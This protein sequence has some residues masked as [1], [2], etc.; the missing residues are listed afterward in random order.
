MTGIA[1]RWDTRVRAWMRRGGAILAS[2][3]LVLL[4][5]AARSGA[6]G[7]PG[8]CDGD[9]SVAIDELVRLV[10]IAL[11]SAAISTCS[12][13]DS[14][15]NGQVSI[16]EI[17]TAVFHGLNGCAAQAPCT[18]AS[19]RACGAADTRCQPGAGGLY[20]CTLSGS[21]FAQLDGENGCESSGVYPS[22]CWTAPRGPC[23]ADAICLVANSPT[24]TASLT[25]TAS[26]TPTTAIP[27][28]ITVTPSA[29]GTAVA[30]ATA[31]ATPTVQPCDSSQTTAC[32]SVCGTAQLGC[33]FNPTP[34]ATGSPTPVVSCFDPAITCAGMGCADGW[35]GF[36]VCGGQGFYTDA[37]QIVVGTPTATPTGIPTG[38]VSAT[39]TAPPTATETPS[40]PAATATASATATQAAPTGT[41]SASPASPTATPTPTATGPAATCP[42]GNREL[43]LTNS[44]G[45]TIWIGATGGAV[46]PVCDCPGCA[47]TV[48]LLAPSL[49]QADQ[50]K[51]AASDAA[52]SGTILC[53]GTSTPNGTYE[54]CGCSSSETCGGSAACN[55]SD[56]T[57]YWTVPTPTSAGGSG[58]VWEL[59]D[60][61]SALFCLPAPAAVG[62]VASPVWWSGN[63]FART[64]CDANGAYCAAGNCTDSSDAPCPPGTGG[65]QGHSLFEVTLQTNANDFYDVS[66]INGAN[67]AIAAAPVGVPTSRPGSVD[68]AYWCG[69]PGAS[70]P[71]T[72]VTPCDWAID[73]GAIP[74]PTPASP[75]P[76]AATPTPPDYRTTLLLTSCPAGRNSTGNLCYQACTNDTD[77]PANS[78]G[79]TH[80]DDGACQCR[81]DSDCAGAYLC[82]TQRAEFVIPGLQRLCGDFAGWWTADDICST[83][84]GLSVTT[85]GP[86]DCS[87]AMQDLLGCTGT[88][89]AS[90]YNLAGQ[91]DPNCCGCATEASNPL[92]ADWPSPAAGAQCYDNNT[93]WA[94]RAQPLLAYLKVACPTAYTYPFDDPTS[95]F[96]C[97]TGGAT[98][99]MGYQVTFSPLPTPGPAMP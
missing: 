39:S 43:N 38:T 14:D 33:C 83:A 36:T 90:C 93:T 55:G 58:S 77:C 53:P 63:I 42:A 35:Y 49:V 75:T 89:A 80:C 98:N 50:C 59:S 60:G 68:P 20:C 66:I 44:S 54:Y 41:P 52:F 72:S 70:S 73:P 25:P 19:C 87:A 34:A 64:G 28:T 30:T 86:L 6:A 7:C 3:A 16:D 15:G 71:T 46:A 26:R 17:L 1:C 4:L 95:T 12:A 21:L 88:N 69:N 48:C 78:D 5:G 24:P 94:A 40:S 91:G 11:G 74:T 99:L 23:H 67:V 79:N 13:G 29:S 47:T 92:S 57:C 18:A 9:G 61:D 32:Q 76:G 96:Q 85:Y 56:S 97:S 2:L 27:P 81:S 37:C 62:Q 84:A 10:N 45:A 82:G 51:C 8:D 22:G 31:T 65:S